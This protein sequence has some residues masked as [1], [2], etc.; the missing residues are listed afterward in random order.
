MVRLPYVASLA[1]TALVATA[2]FSQAQQPKKDDP[3]TADKEVVDSRIRKKQAVACLNFRKELGLPFA[4]LSTLGSRIAAARRESD[5]VAMASA[6]MELA[7]AERIAGKKAS[8]TSHALINEAT[9]MASLRREPK[10]THAVLLAAQQAAAEEAT[11]AR[12]NREIAAAKDQQQS[13]NEAMANDAAAVKLENQPKWIGRKVLITNFSTQYV[14]LSVNGRL[15]IQIA[16][17]EKR[18]YVIEHRWNPTVLT[19]TGDQDI[20]SWGPRIIWG[21]FNTYTWNIYG[22]YQTP[23]Q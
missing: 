16:P 10:E 2:T 17:G 8:V 3:A 9:D 7:S 20:D 19:A 21:K 18:I 15:K 11:I 12:I 23:E 5:P 22:D 6:A 14:D 4:T 13:I 1:L